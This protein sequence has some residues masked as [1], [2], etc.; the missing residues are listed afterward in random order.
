MEIYESILKITLNGST[1]LD[2]GDPLAV[3]GMAVDSSQQVD[4]APVVRSAGVLTFSRGN[5]SN[6]LEWTII[7]PQY[8]MHDA[9]VKAIN[10]VITAPSETG[11]LTIETETGWIYQIANATIESMPAEY[12]S[13]L[14]RRTFRVI[15]GTMSLVTEGTFGDPNDPAQTLPP[16]YRMADGITLFT[17]PSG[18]YFIQP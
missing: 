13:S 15:G 1:L 4:V 10:H 12:Q 8:S 16:H 5:R 11:T 3:D 2:F 9:A 18:D 7:E 14:S 17:S 6:G